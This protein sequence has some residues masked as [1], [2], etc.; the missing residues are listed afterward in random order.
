[1]APRQ[2]ESVVKGV[3]RCVHEH[4][5]DDADNREIVRRADAGQKNGAFNTFDE[6]RAAGTL[7]R[8]GARSTG[9][10]LIA[11]RRPGDLALLYALVRR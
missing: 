3:R 9:H 6:L 2:H 7:V 11:W 1:M 4:R 5:I 10:R 8:F